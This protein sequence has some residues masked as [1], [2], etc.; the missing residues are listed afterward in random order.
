M[1]LG[2]G[3]LDVFADLAG[4]LVY[5]AL[6]RVWVVCGVGVIYSTGGGCGLFLEW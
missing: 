6:L 3:G 1:V 2:G 5:V 4:G